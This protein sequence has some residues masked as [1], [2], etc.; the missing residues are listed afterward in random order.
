[1]NY[2]AE[3]N[4]RQSKVVR[5]LLLANSSNYLEYFFGLIV[6]MLIAR[7]LGP[8]EFGTYVFLIWLVSIAVAFANEGLALSVTKH[9]A[10]IGNDESTPDS[11]TIIHYF[12]G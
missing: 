7:S 6:S 11:S 4:V 2:S 5:N 1:M 3:S 10:E 9:I 12:E 8:S